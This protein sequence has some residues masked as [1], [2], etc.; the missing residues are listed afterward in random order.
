MPIVTFL[1]SRRTSDV[2][3]RTSLYEAARRA[4]LPVASSCS[5][6][7]ICGKCNMQI[8]SGSE[9]L[10]R[11]SQAE[12]DLLRREQRPETDRISCRAYVLGDCTVTTRYW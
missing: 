7:F 10:T 5:A 9:G 12:R 2:P 3:P 11:Q 6:Q 4:G 8:V 1:P